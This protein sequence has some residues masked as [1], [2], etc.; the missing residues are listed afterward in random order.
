LARLPRFEPASSSWQSLNQG[1]F[2]EIS[3]NWE[4]YER[5]LAKNRYVQNAED[6][7]SDTRKFSRYLLTNIFAEM[8]NLTNAHGLEHQNA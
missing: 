8:K 3:M 2:G 4:D 6:L 1:V 7:L 5:F